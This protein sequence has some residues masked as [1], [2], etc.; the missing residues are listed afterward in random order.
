VGKRPPVVEVGNLGAARDFT[1][2]RDVVRA[3]TLMLERGQPGDVF[4]VCTGKAH[5]MQS[6]LRTLVSLS[7]V[8]VQVREVPERVRPV[9][10][11]ILYGTYE[12]L[13]QRT[14]WEPR[15]SIERSLRDVLDEWRQRVRAPTD[16]PS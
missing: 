13:R 16:R 11:P 15:F 14:G 3:Y 6:I 4:N 5:T 7:A 2:V 12:R 10:I 9:D 8:P 1:D